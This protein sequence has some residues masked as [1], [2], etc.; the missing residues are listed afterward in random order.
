MS[1]S[2][3]EAEYMAVSEVAMEILYVVGILKFLVLRL[4]YP[5]EVKVNNIEAV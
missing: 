1:L 2:S 4:K 3:T 5:V